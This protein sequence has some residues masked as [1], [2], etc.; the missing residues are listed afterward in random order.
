MPNVTISL[1]EDTL[2][3]VREYAHRQNTSVNALIRQLL[4]QRVRR[5]DGAWIDGCFAAMDALAVNSGGRTWQREDL[6]DV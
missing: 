4:E 3:A 6:Y 2:R 5:S 1:D